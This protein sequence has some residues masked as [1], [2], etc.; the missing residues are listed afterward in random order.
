[1]AKSSLKARLI[2]INTLIVSVLVVGGAFATIKASEKA[3]LQMLDSGLLNRAREL[4]TSPFPMA[5]PQP[6][7]NADG[8]SGSVQGQQ[9]QGQRP[10]FRNGEPGRMGRP[11]RGP[12]PD[13]GRPVWIL[14]SGEVIGPPDRR[15]AWSD[16]MVKQSLAGQEVVATVESDEGPLRTASVPMMRDKKIIGVVQT[17][18]PIEGLLVASEA[19]QQVLLW[20]LPLGLAAAG[21][22]GWLVLRNSL[23][24]VERA[25]ETATAIAKTGALNERLPVSGTDEMSRLSGAFN[26][27]LDTI[28]AAQSEK[29]LALARVEAALEDQ[30]RFTADASHELRTPLASI[31][32]AIETLRRSDALEP[33]AKRQL[34]LMDGVSK[35]MARLIDDLLTLARADSGSLRVNRAA[36]DIKKP[37]AEALLVHGLGESDRL[38]VSFPDEALMSIGDEDAVRRIA[39]NLLANALRHCPEGELELGGRTDG[40][41]T[42]FWVRDKGE[43]MTP[44]DAAQAGT[45]FF[46]ADSARNRETG[47]HGLGLAICR[48]LAEAM[49]GGLSLSSELGQGTCVQVWLL[50]G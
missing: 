21:L 16:P 29:D 39:V 23:Q 11:P 5:P 10:G 13:F 44:E 36:L 19:G 43:G 42:F 40:I 20:I 24:P 47:G 3:S 6:H 12:G 30:K 22:A 9:R 41:K 8:V 38:R 32:L 34:S 35:G 14:S 27:M 31:R 45:R 46:R 7:P 26:E 25:T 48:S 2:F 33:D 18:Q 17:V 15:A 37:L 1:M 28:A 4:S 50:R 49:G